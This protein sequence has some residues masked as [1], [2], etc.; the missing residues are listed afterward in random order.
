MRL[1]A[2]YFT[3]QAKQQVFPYQQNIYNPDLLYYAVLSDNVLAAA[4]VVNST[5]LNTKEPEKS[6]FHVV[7][8]ALNFPE[9]FPQPITFLPQL[10][11]QNSYWFSSYHS[12]F[13]DI[14]HVRR[15]SN[16]P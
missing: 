10:P 7:P 11:S 15:W 16:I 13:I 12:Q 9:M 1:T 6:V 3:L 2:E 8:D 4:V 14:W 5:V